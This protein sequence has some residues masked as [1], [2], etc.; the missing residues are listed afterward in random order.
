MQMRIRITLWM[1]IL[2]LSSLLNGCHS[3]AP[4]LS[5]AGTIG[6]GLSQA[7]PQNQRILVLAA[8]RDIK[9]DIVSENIFTYQILGTKT[10]AATAVNSQ[11]LSTMNATLK[12]LDYYRLRS[13]TLNDPNVLNTTDIQAITNHSYTALTP[14]AQQFLAD[15]IKDRHVDTIVLLTQDGDRPL[16]FDLKCELSKNNFYYHASI[17]PHLYLYKIYVIDAHTLKI[18]TWITG[19]ATG[20]LPDV[21]LC[22]PVAQ[23]T[24]RDLNDLNYTVMNR[25]NSAVADDL[26]KTLT[27]TYTRTSRHGNSNRS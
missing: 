21:H 2:L 10:I 9:V 5:S 20:N 22:K 27:P 12:N 1:L 16:A 19:S 4:P 26:S 15:F 14:E 24:R 25:L 3:G 17:Q 18:I 13:A 23:F 11:L 6:P 7:I 8:L